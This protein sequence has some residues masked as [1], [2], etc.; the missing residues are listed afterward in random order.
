[1]LTE[2]QVKP[3]TWRQIPAAYEYRP[4]GDVMTPKEA[5]DAFNRLHPTYDPGAAWW[6]EGI[7]TLYVPM[8]YARAE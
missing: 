5:V 7:H 3:A 8:N 2:A 4:I 1:M 6:V